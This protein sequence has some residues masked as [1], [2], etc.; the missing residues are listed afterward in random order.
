MTNPPLPPLRIE[1]L[2]VDDQPEVAL[3]IARRAIEARLDW[4]ARYLAPDERRIGS[5]STLAVLMSQG[6]FDA[7]TV[8]AVRDVLTDTNPVAHGR[9]VSPSVA[10]VVVESAAGVSAAL[11]DMIGSLQGQLLDMGPRTRLAYA[12]LALPSTTRRSLAKRL[13]LFDEGDDSLH[14]KDAARAVFERARKANL[15]ANLWTE[16]AREN[17]DIPA[18]PPAELE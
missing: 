11:D 7:K 4:L 6:G 1:G 9:T 13:D 14:R 8:R 17:T 18:K 16:I 12:F 5:D 3:V 2:E 10:A 15:L